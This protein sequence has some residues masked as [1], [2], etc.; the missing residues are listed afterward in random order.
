[1]SMIFKSLWAHRKQN[2]G[3]FAEI[4]IIACL[5][6]FLVDFVTTSFYAVHLCRPA[7]EVEKDHLCVGQM[8]IIRNESATEGHFVTEEERQ[9]IYV[10]KNKL[11]NMP[12]VA[13]VCLAYDYLG[14]NLRMYTWQTLAPAD[15]TTRTIGFAR[16]SYY[17]NERFFETQGLQTIEG[18]P[19]AETLSRQIPQDGIVITRSVARDLFGTDQAV[20]KRVVIIDEYAYKKYKAKEYHTIS[21]VVEDVRQSPQERYPYMAFFPYDDMPSA[22]CHLMLRLKPDA[23]AD[24]FVKRLSPTLLNDFHAGICVLAR[25]ETY[26]EHYKKQVAQTTLVQQLATV[27]IVLFCIITVLGVLGTFWLQVR[28][29]QEDFGIMRAFGATKG[30][31]FRKLLAEGSILTFLAT[32]TGCLI[33]LQFAVNFDLLSD[34]AA[35]GGSGRETDWVTQFWPHFLIVSTMVYLLILLAV[36]IGVTLPAWD[37]CRKKVV[38]ALRTE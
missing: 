30:H 16:V 23:D 7:G 32:L 1:M 15:D 2:S 24:A 10:I 3:L 12:E 4:A 13:S 36:S 31:I 29:R 28:K 19:E 5:G 22:D 25:L 18:S 34:G 9:G 27:P 14:C 33:W 37:V 17:Q 8:A 21:G 6:W 20:G 11:E 35:F 38:E 26:R